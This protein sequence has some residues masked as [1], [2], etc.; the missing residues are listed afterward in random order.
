MVHYNSRR[1]TVCDDY[2]DNNDAQVLCRMLGF[3]GGTTRL[4]LGEQNY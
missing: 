1:G 2:L 4:D 3:K